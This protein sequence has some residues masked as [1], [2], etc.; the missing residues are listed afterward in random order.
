MYKKPNIAVVLFGLLV[1][2]VYCSKG[3]Q[4]TIEKSVC[5]TDSIG[6]TNGHLITGLRHRDVS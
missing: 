2:Q 5:V 6:V 4:Q 3:N 1:G